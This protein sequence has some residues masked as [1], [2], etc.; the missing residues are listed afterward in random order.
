MNPEQDFADALGGDEV[1]F[2]A[3]PQ[4]PLD[5]DQVT[6]WVAQLARVRHLRDEYDTAYAAAVARLS[7]RHAERKAAL[8]TQEAWFAEA[9]EMYHRT[10]LA[11][12]PQAKTIH[13]PAGVLKST[14]TQPSWEFYD[15][16]AF[17]EWAMENLPQVFS[18]PLPPPAPKVVKNE[19]KKALKDEADEAL[20]VAGTSDA[21]LT[22]DGVPVPGLRVKPAGRNYKVET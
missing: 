11:A 16:A 14:A 9:L 1:D 13:T 10:V 18:E 3:K 22:H 17:A 6:Q 15:E 8:D 12:D 2:D 7:A 20:K 5:L 21:V 4:A 19:V